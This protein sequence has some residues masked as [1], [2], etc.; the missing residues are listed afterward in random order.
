MIDIN[1]K[2]YPITKTD[3]VAELYSEKDGVD[4]KYVC[5]T[6]LSDTIAD[7]FYRA[8]PHPTFGNKYFAVLFRDDVPYIAAADQVE[9]LVFGIVE[10]DEGAFEYSRS[11]HDFKSFK[12]GNMIDGGRD[13]IRSSGNVLTCIVRDGSFIRTGVNAHET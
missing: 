1:I 9:S 2:H 5:T 10:N 6:E 4:V 3:Q 11:R 8:T 12:N 13:Y 7:I